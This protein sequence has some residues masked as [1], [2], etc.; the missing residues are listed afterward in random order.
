MDINLAYVR[1]NFFFEIF[2]LLSLEYQSY[3][4]SCFIYV[5][6]CTMSVTIF[7]ITAAGFA[8]YRSTI[9]NEYLVYNL[10]LT[11]YLRKASMI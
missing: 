11:T 1:K 8:Y 9:D 2:F 4:R 10:T 6:V 5:Y 7:T 3:E